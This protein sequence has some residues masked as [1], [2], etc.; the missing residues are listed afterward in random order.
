MNLNIK[1]CICN[2]S[3]WHWPALVPWSN[4]F[5]RYSVNIHSISTIIVFVFTLLRGHIQIDIQRNLV[6]LHYFSVGDWCSVVH[7]ISL[8][9]ANRYSIG[10]KCEVVTGFELAFSGM[11]CCHGTHWAPTPP[12]KTTYWAP[13]QQL[14]STTA[15]PTILDFHR[16]DAAASYAEVPETA[17]KTRQFW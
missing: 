3:I 16:L 1:R 14:D 12:I 17:V 15:E 5:R 2:F 9:V 7:L 11:G 10:N 4:W 8:Q 6:W 13:N